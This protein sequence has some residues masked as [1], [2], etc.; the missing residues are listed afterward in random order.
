MLSSELVTI[1][2]LFLAASAMARWCR[3]TKTYGIVHPP[4]AIV[5][6]SIWVVDKCHEM[7]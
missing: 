1:S 5:S 4:A 6:T 3:E 7:L 2:V